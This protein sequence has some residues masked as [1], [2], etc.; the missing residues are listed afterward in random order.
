[1]KLPIEG[2]CACRGIRYECT[3]STFV[4]AHCH[5]RDCQY[6]SGT[7]HSSVLVVPVSTVQ[8]T[9]YPKYYESISSD[10]NKVRR[11]FCPECGTPLFSGSDAFKEVMGIKASSLDN[12]SEFEPVI[13]TWTSSAPPWDI[14]SPD[15]HKFLKDM[16]A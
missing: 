10:G 7:G 15:T 5:C 6:S 8:I 11:G 13:E 2:G 16:E 9:G 1:M 12:P 4:M 14:L 3:A